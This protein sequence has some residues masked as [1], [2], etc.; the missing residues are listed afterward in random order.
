MASKLEDVTGFIKE[1]A[2]A[3]TLSPVQA[4]HLSELLAKELHDEFVS[5]Q[6]KGK[7][8]TIAK[9]KDFLQS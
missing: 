5:G 9:I 8:D 3:G 2:E 6:V 1:L 7:L 4:Y